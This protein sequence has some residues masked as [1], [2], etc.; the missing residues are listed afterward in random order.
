[1]NDFA[2]AVMFFVAV[3]AALS[4]MMLGS[5]AIVNADYT[6]E[7]TL[8]YKKNA[9]LGTGAGLLVFTSGAMINLL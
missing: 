5:V 9:L 2:S 7:M 3:G 8:S 6:K 4:L 1:M